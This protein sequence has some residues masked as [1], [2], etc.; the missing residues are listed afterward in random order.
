MPSK[1]H[2]LRF[3]SGGPI[4][5]EIWYIRFTQHYT[6]C[7]IDDRTVMPKQLLNAINMR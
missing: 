2:K 6:V 7:W 1:V 4:S 3:D 5:S